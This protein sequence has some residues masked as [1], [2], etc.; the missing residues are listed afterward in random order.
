[1]SMNRYLRAAPALA[2]VFAGAC[3]Q[4]LTDVN[5]NPNAPEDVPPAHLLANAIQQGVGYNGS[6]YGVAG[7]EYGLRLTE[8]WSQ[9]LA[10][11]QYNEEDLYTPRPSQLE[12]VWNSWYAGTLKDLSVAQ[13]QGQKT[14]DANLSAVASILSQWGFSQLTDTY[15]DIP[16]SQALQL[17]GDSGTTRPVYDTQKDVYYGILSKLTAASGSLS[18]GA[19]DWATGDLLYHGNIAAWK[20]FSNSLRMRYAMRIVNA[21]PAKAQAE[22]TAA[23]TAGG[24]ASNADNALMQW[25]TTQ[26]NQNPWYDYWYNQDRYGDFVVSAAMVDTLTHRND[27]RLGVYAAKTSDDVYRGLE[28]GTLP[29]NHNHKIS[30]YSTVGDAYLA[31]DAPTYLMTYSEVLFLQAE[32]AQ[33]G[34]IPGGA[35]QAAVLYGKAIQAS[36]DQNGIGDQA[37]AYMAQPSVAYNGLPSIYLQ[38]WIALY[39]NG[40]EAYSLYRR[41]GVPNLTPTTG[42]K[43]PSRLTYPNQE[44]LLNTENRAAAVARSGGTSIFDKL[45]WEKP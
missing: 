35:A 36:F 39:G 34:W 33:R 25:R 43:V 40:P 14:G 27:P 45:W 6:G 9:Q 38:E 22:F 42:A 31:A 24:F 2:L 13:Q 7:S 19:G 8:I 11:S 26:P 23:N 3:D 12:G 1:M 17:A 15:G 29:E 30:E 28:N 41:T 21:D 20:K 37:A 5:K 16:Y 32:A 18:G 44:S 4:G 10:Q